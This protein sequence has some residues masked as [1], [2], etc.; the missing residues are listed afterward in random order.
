MNY[1]VMDLEWNQ[2]KE[3]EQDKKKIPFEIIEIGAVK[4]DSNRRLV[5][6]FQRVIKPQ[7]YLE[8]F[9]ITQSL[10][11][12]EAEELEAG[13]TFTQAVTD[14]FE[15]CGD[16]Y[17]FC[18]WGNMDLIELQRNMEY[19]RI[20]SFLTKAF[21]YYD[22]QK[23]FSLQV[24]GRKNPRTLEYAV[25]Y[26]N[27]EKTADF[28]RA[29]YDAEYTA[30]IFQCLKATLIKKY[31]SI[32]Y[33][34]NPKSLEE[35]IHLNYG[36]Y[37]K[38]IS[39]E[40]ATREEALNDPQIKELTCFVCKRLAVRKIDWFS[41]NPKNYYCLGHC[42]RH[43]YLKGRIQMNRTGDNKRFVVK[44]TSRVNRE[45]AKKLKL[46]YDEFIVKHASSSE[47]L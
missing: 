14:F 23:L 15:W 9:P 47:E 41:N 32:D 19:Y 16:S 36:N 1:I 31:Y 27:L 17:I 44:I 24:E 20:G 29:L 30:R 39:R 7:I 25:E 43:G 18:T 34:H 26:F 6:T 37:T 10:V 22:V 11:Q 21:R 46:R 4:L 2:G 33:Y 42:S 38:Y 3:T 12:I 45:G 13:I 40:F 5:E 35:E 28:H 8:M